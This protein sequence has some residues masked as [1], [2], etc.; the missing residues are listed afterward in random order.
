MRQSFCEFNDE[1]LPVLWRESRERFRR[2]LDPLDQENLDRENDLMY[3]LF[4]EMID[5]GMV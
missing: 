3:D 4:N 2:A 1:E 5:R